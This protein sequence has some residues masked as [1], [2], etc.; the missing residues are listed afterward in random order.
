MAG[1]YIHIP[2]CKQKCHYCNFYSFASNNYRELFVDALLN[3]I[4]LRKNF[5]GKEKIN[6]VYFGGGTPSLLNID[7]LNKIIQHLGDVFDLSD[8]TETTLEANPD[9]LNAEKIHDLKKHTP[10]NRLS[11]G[12]QSFF[13]DDL[14]YLN[15]IHNSKH[16]ID[17]IEN[18]IK[19][20]FHNMTVD[21]IYGIPGLTEK[22]W[23]ENLRIFFDF[24]IKHLS[25]YSLTV[26]PKT[27]L[28][29]LI[30]K[31][32]IKNIVEEESIRHFEILQEESDKHAF[33]HYEISNFAREGHYSK[34]NSI[35]WLGGHYSG[36]GPSAHSF[37]GK[38]RQWNVSNM[39]QYV[40]S[41]TVD[42]IVREKETLTIQQQYNE[43]V[44]TSL[45]TSWGCDTLHIKNVFGD[46]FVKLFEKEAEK[47][48]LNN[49]LLK[50]ES[51]YKLSKQAKLFADGI[52]SDF[53]VF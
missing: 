46:S 50:T 13:D 25:S 11:I 21:L 53:F 32:K 41:D 37:N 27:A 10:I 28:N 40:E 14:L 43:Y 20:G 15:R 7:E 4:N 42:K 24:N 9:D 18:A 5:L 30:N 35:Y 19:A 33:I 47:H 8:E 49:K 17:S 6:T 16:A 31:N 52:A 12:V 38:T 36:F 3:E 29:A 48:I 22:K 26:E 1:I 39:K 23:R 45:R 51:V 44:M 2:Y 34:H